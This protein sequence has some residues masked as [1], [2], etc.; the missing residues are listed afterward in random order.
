[1]TTDLNIPLQTGASAVLDLAHLGDIEGGS[2]QSVSATM[3][4]EKLSAA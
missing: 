1:M 2:A 3:H 4:R